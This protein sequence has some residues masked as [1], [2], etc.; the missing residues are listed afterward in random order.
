[1][2]EVGAKITGTLGKTFRIIEIKE[3][4]S[5]A[6]TSLKYP[7]NAIST[8]DETIKN[9]MKGVISH[10]EK[11]IRVN[12]IS[13]EIKTYDILVIKSAKKLIGSIFKRK[14]Y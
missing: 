9:S 5:T 14:Q 10:C 8:I 1:M 3:S 6:V 13:R 4:A 2:K 12:K 7:V 11:N